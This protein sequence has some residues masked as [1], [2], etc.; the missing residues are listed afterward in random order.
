MRETHL[1][2]SRVLVVI[3]HGLGR[4][5]EHET[6]AL[7]DLVHDLVHGLYDRPVPSEL[8][9]AEQRHDRE[10]TVE[11][12]EDSLRTCVLQHDTLNLRQC[13]YTI[14]MSVWGCGAYKTVTLTSVFSCALSASFNVSTAF[15]MSSLI[16]SWA[17][18]SGDSSSTT[19]GRAK[20]VVSGRGLRLNRCCS[21]RRQHCQ[22]PVIVT[23]QRSPVKV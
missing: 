13:L 14:G 3:K 21:F 20:V 19:S 5:V 16:T 10:E 7:G 4:D 11:V 2:I 17:K 6:R 18:S 15:R 9:G 1:E 8:Q 23:S 12:F 22:L